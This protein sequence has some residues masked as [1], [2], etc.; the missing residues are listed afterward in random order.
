MQKKRVSK[1]DVGRLFEVGTWPS[2][3]I[4]PLP[5][6]P[7]LTSFVHYLI[8]YL[9]KLLQILTVDNLNKCSVL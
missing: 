9:I 8:S 4:Q 2:N 1:V 6:N 3:Q 7:L 5:L